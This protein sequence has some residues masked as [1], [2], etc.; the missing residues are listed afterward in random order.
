MNEDHTNPENLK[1]IRGCYIDLCH[2]YTSIQYNTMKRRLIKVHKGG[3]I[4]GLSRT[5]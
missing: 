2:F 3:D 4:A 1:S 5:H